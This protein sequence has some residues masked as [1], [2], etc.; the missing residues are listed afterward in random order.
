[1][2]ITVVL[3]GVVW[4]AYPVG[5]DSGTG[6][7]FSVSGAGASGAGAS[8][9][10]GAVGMTGAGAAVVLSGQGK[11]GSGSPRRQKVADAGVA[12]M[13]IDRAMAENLILRLL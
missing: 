10:A 9:T 5:C 3:S 2:A 12:A 7:G 1:M 13:A 8:G 4:C 6:F 11:N